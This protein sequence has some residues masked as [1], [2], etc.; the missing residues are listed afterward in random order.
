MP[1]GREE[2]LRGSR[3]AKILKNYWQQNEPA[4]RQKLQR[5]RRSLLEEFAAR[6]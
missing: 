2:R 6:V 3:G 1:I 4:H 5:P